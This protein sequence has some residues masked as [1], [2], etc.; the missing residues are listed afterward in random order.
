MTLSFVSNK[1]LF[2]ILLDPYVG[3]L[4]LSSVR[5]NF[6]CLWI[7]ST[8]HHQCSQDCH[9]HKSSKNGNSGNRNRNL[10]IAT[11]VHSLGCAAKR[12]KHL[13]KESRLLIIP[14]LLFPYLFARTCFMAS[15]SVSLWQ[16]IFLITSPCLYVFSLAKFF[17]VFYLTWLL[18]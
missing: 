3:L 4:A 8:L 2:N 16:H 6:L 7:K 5:E 9:S 13:N 1:F 11:V 15:C 10:T 12:N 14:C 17:H 18:G